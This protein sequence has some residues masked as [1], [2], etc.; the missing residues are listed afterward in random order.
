MFAIWILYLNIRDVRTEGGGGMT[1][2]GQKQTRGCFSE[3]GRPQRV[4]MYGSLLSDK[5]VINKL[6]AEY[7]AARNM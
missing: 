3:C 5:I 6:Q 7:I 2:R 4:T 1:Q